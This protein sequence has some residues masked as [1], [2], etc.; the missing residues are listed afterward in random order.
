[1]FGKVYTSSHCGGVHDPLLGSGWS[2]G[3]LNLRPF[4]IGQYIFH[5]DHQDDLGTKPLLCIYS[6]EERVFCISKDG[7]LINVKSFYYSR[8][9]EK[10]WQ[11]IN[12]Q[13]QK[14]QN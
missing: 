14:N 4:Q 1:M 12:Y 7:I 11:K 13:K 5:R 9:W 3:K 8:R 2:L 6:Q 10:L